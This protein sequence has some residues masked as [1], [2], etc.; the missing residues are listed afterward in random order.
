MKAE[1]LAEPIAGVLLLIIFL[2]YMTLLG[3]VSIVRWAARPLF[4]L[5]IL[6]LTLKFANAH[7]WYAPECCNG[8]DCRP[9]PAEEVI[10]TETGWKHLPS[11]KEFR[12]DQ[13]K[14]S[15]DRH[16]HICVSR[17]GT[18]YCIYILQGT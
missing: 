6:I 11:G 18:P 5:A 14:P 1:Q 13:V 9:V 12:K 7:S 2:A 17:Y 8:E 15:Q 10:E 3:I 16:F 4:V